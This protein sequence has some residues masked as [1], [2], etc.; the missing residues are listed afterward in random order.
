MMHTT[1]F[2]GYQLGFV[3]ICRQLKLDI[4][5]GFESPA[6]KTAVLSTEIGVLQEF[7]LST[8]RA[9]DTCRDDQDFNRLFERIQD[10]TDKLQDDLR[11]D[12]MV[13]APAMTEVAK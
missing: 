3:Y 10:L 9:I 7:A 13:E 8:R 6:A 11:G 2:Q 4:P 5:E 12:S 1:D